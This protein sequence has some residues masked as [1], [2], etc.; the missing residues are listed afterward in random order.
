MGRG[1]ERRGRAGEVAKLLFF[2]S[3]ASALFYSWEYCRQSK[4][5]EM[6]IS[7][8]HCK[9]AWGKERDHSEREELQQLKK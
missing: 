3:R 8:A 2:N 7:V 1:E 4:E 9:V 5:V 6:G